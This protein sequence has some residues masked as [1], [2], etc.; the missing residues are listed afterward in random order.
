MANTIKSLLSISEIARLTS[1]SKATIYRCI[2]AGIFPKPLKIGL[3]RV[4][5]NSKDV[6]DFVANTN[7]NVAAKHQ[8]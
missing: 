1:L 7:G 6:F 8:K 2:K 3:R 5:W 4:G